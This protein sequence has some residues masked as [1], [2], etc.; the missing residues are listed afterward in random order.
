MGIKDVV[1]KARAVKVRPG[2]QMSVGEMMEILDYR[3]DD[4][5]GIAITAFEFG[6]MQGMKAAK[7]EAKE[8]KAGGA[9]T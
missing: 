4:H 3:K 5:I 1:E 2:L 7:L 6:Y 8:G 9:R